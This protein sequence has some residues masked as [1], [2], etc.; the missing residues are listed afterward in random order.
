MA[1][2]TVRRYIADLGYRVHS[3]AS[4]FGDERLRQGLDDEDWLPIVGRE[5]WAVFGRDQQILAR[6]HELAAWLDAKIHMFLLPGQIRKEEILA[7]LAHNLREICAVAVA[8]RPNVYWLTVQG[9]QTYERRKAARER[10]RG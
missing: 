7:L 2:R 4:V 5:G 1:G 10:R 9:L 8:R 3:A 6:P